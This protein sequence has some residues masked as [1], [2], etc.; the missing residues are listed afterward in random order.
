MIEAV[1]TTLKTN[2]YVHSRCSKTSFVK[3]ELDG[4]Y[5]AKVLTVV[6]SS[7]PCKFSHYISD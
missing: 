6:S 5:L 2:I 3:F 1:S 7:I 4:V